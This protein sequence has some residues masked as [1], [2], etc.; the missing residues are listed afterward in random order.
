MTFDEYFQSKH[1][2]LIESTREEYDRINDPNFIEMGAEYMRIERSSEPLT[3]L[4]FEYGKDKTIHHITWKYVNPR[5][6]RDIDTRMGISNSEA[7]ILLKKI[8]SGNGQYPPDSGK[9]KWHFI[10]GQEVRFWAWTSRDYHTKKISLEIGFTIGDI[11]HVVRGVSWTKKDEKG[12]FI[13]LT[14]TAKDR[15]SISFKR[16][17]TMREIKLEI[18]GDSHYNVSKRSMDE[19]LHSLN[20]E[21]SN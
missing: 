14:E 10:N 3:P 20:Q 13:Y 7:P 18:F 4:Y 2:G 19:I 15:R 6:T 1:K 8:K 11:H 12:C 16:G 17:L 5:N 9:V 21:N